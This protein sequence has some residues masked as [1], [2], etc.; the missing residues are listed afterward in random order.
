MSGTPYVSLKRT[1]MILLI[2]YV[3]AAVFGLLAGAA[4]TWHVDPFSEC[5]LFSNSFGGK[6]YY[7]HEASKSVLLVLSMRNILRFNFQ[8]V[9][10]SPT[11]TLAVSSEPSSCSTSP[12]NTGESSS[13]SST[14][15]RY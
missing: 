13:I 10:P 5:L 15:V 11:C 8:F 14:Q 2:V 3:L 6:L 9:R 7:G 4:L 1:Y 12:S